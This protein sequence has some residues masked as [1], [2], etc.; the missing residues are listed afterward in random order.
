MP[1]D[2]HDL[3]GGG[4]TAARRSSTPPTSP[5]VSDGNRS[6]LGAAEGAT[7][8]EPPSESPLFATVAQFCTLG[9]AEEGGAGTLPLPPPLPMPA[10]ASEG[11]GADAHAQGVGGGQQEAV[12]VGGGGAVTP[13]VLPSLFPQGNG[14]GWTA[15]SEGV[16]MVLSSVD[17]ESGAAAAAAAGA[18]A[19][20]ATTATAS[21]ASPGM[22]SLHSVASQDVIVKASVC[23]KK[24]CFIDCL[25]CGRA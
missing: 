1:G 16:R 4:S 3:A 21:S 23:K 17:H 11:R 15:V 12:A 10:A 20:A 9:V 2:A 18:G 14:T 5:A 19:G 24:G 13:A 22:F 6:R 8:R 7:T 25:F